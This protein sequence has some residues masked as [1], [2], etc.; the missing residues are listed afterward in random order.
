MLRPDYYGEMQSAFDLAW[1]QA[2]ILLTTAAQWVAAHC[3]SALSATL[4][5]SW[6]LLLNAAWWLLLGAFDLAAS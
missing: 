1:L 3:C 5:Q 4:W 6:L 2:G